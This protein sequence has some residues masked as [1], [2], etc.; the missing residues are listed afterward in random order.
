MTD[1]DLIRG[2]LEGSER[3]H[4]ELFNRYETRALRVAYSLLGDRVEAEDA[5]QEAFVQAFRSM[6]RL[7][8]GSEFG[9]WLFRSVVWAARNR[10]RSVRRW[11]EALMRRAT[12]EVARV[13]PGPEDLDTR[14]SVVEALRQLPSDQREVVVLRF[15]LDLAEAEVAAIVGCPVGTVK[16][17]AARGLRRMA[18]S[19]E[20]AW[21]A[22]K[23]EGSSNA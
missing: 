9:P 12:Q 13:D 19:P 21:R 17:R 8:P 2:C 1:Q 5:A 11:R 18:N 15:Y 6:S 20:L 4:E 22:P 16:S 23:L 7:R 14:R 3:S 10:Q